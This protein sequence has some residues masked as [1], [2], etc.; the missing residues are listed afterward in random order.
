MKKV[1]MIL[2]MTISLFS[3][4]CPK[5]LFLG[6]DIIGKGMYVS[7]NSNEA[8]EMASLIAL[9]DLG[10]QVSSLLQEERSMIENETFSSQMTTRYKTVL[11]AYEVVSKQYDPKRH[12]AKV[13]LKIKN[14]VAKEHLCRPSQK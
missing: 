1:L 11:K 12:E 6:H 14:T 2:L 3:D 8:L 4:D 9:D 7:I 5:T 10:K 13:V